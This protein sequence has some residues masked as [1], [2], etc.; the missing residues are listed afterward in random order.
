M[1]RTGEKELV[2]NPPS[3]QGKAAPVHVQMLKL[4]QQKKESSMNLLIL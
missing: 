2:Q 3:A 1:K 4:I